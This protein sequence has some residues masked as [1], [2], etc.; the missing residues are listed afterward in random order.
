MRAGDRITPAGARTPGAEWLDH[1][2]G[3]APHLN[4][5][6]ID[7]G[8]GVSAL[9]CTKGRSKPSRAT[10]MPGAGLTGARRGKA[11]SERPALKPYWGKPAVRNFRGGDGDGDPRHLLTRQIP[12]SPCARPERFTAP[13][14]PGSRG[15][16]PAVRERTWERHT[17]SGGE[18][19]SA[20]KQTMGSRSAPMV[21]RTPGNQ[22]RRD[23]AEGRRAPRWQSRA[24]ET[25][26]AL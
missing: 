24:R 19:I 8:N 17:G 26:R 21:P 14:E 13:N 25:R 2:N 12:S 16:P 4:R 5:P 3:G 11:L 1:S 9:R 7:R 6:G 15:M 18:S 20:R 23:P 22:A 10:G